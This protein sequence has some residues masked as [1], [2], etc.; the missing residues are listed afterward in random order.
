L[1]GKKIIAYVDPTGAKDALGIKK[2]KYAVRDT[3][4]NVT[5]YDSVDAL[6]NAGY[7]TKNQ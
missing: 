5:T 6:T 2:L 4:G 1:G 7:T 3:D